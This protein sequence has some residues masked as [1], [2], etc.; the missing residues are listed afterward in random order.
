MLRAELH[1]GHIG[2]RFDQCALLHPM[3]IAAPRRRL[4]AVRC[5]GH[6]NLPL[7]HSQVLSLTCTAVVG[8]IEG[9]GMGQTPTDFLPHDGG[10]IEGARGQYLTELR[11]RPRHLPHAAVMRLCDSAAL[12]TTPSFHKWTNRRCAQMKEC[13]THVTSVTSAHDTPSNWPSTP[14]RHAR[15]NPRSAMDTMCY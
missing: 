15:S 3:P 10:A 5:V 1:V 8:C 9:K 12:H 13:S 14:T 2:A 11:M 4:R 6:C 7:H